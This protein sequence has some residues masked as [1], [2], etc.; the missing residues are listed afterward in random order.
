[1]NTAIEESPD[2]TPVIS[3]VLT[4]TGCWIAAAAGS[5]AKAAARKTL[6]N[7]RF[8]V[9]NLSNFNSLVPFVI[10][11]SRTAWPRFNSFLA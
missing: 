11:T 9:Y 7:R 2:A 10:I 1:L 8:I 5:A 3:P 4:F 6:W